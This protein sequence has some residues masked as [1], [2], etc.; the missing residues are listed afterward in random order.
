MV[1][2]NIRIKEIQND[3]EKRNVMK[4]DKKKKSDMT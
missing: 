4:G 1:K 3:H 2:K